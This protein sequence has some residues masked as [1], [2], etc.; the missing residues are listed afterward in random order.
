MATPSKP[1][2]RRSIRDPASRKP[3]AVKP[4][5]RCRDPGRVAWLERWRTGPGAVTLGLVGLDEGQADTG[6]V[7]LD[8]RG[9]SHE[10][11]PVE[12]GRVGGRARP[13]AHS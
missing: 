11:A 4:K 1:S 3:P 13:T 12:E 9:R 2:L 8:D 5:G 10:R 6:S 7:A